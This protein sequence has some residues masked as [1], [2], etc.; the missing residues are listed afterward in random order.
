M[1]HTIQASSPKISWKKLR[2]MFAGE[3]VEL[4]DFEWD[5]STAHPLWAKVRHHD[6]DRQE[7]IAKIGHS[8]AI[9]DAVLIYV[10]VSDSIVSLDRSQVAI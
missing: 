10:G 8:E 6:S 5:W 9:A 2:E 7:L 1:K 3:W 4:T